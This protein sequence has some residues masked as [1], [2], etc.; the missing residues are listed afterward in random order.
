MQSMLILLALYLAVAAVVPLLA[1]RRPRAAGALAALAPAVTAGWACGH[2]PT[3]ISGGAPAAHAAWARDLGLLLDVRLDALALVMLVLVGGVGAVI[4]VYAGWYVAPARSALT[5]GALVGFAG[6]MSGLVLA[7]NLFVLYV[8][9][10]LTTVCSFLLI[11][12]ERP[13][14]GAHRR[15]AAQAALT[16]TSFGFVMLAGF[17]VLGQAASTYRVSAIVATPP[18]GTPVTVASV[19]ILLGAFAKSAQVPFHP[20]LPAAMV[21]STPVSAY[22]HAAAMVKAGVYL[23]ARLAPA[24]AGL[25]GWRPLVITVG[26][27]TLLVGGWRA[28]RQ[29]DLKRLLAFGTVS[30]LGL[31]MVLL[32]AG[33]R[34]AALAG[35]A[36]LLAHGLFKAPLFLAVGVLERA[37]GTRSAARLAAVRPRLPV[38][39]VAVAAAI[40]SMI[41]VPPFLGY[42]AKEAALSAFIHGT[43]ADMA[44]LAAILAGTTLTIAYGLRFLRAFGG[45]SKPRDDDAVRRAG[46]GGASGTDEPSGRTRRP[47]PAL[48]GP[49]VVLA[50]AGLAA[51]LTPGLLQSLIAPYADTLP[52]RAPGTPGYALALGHG[53]GAPVL[54]SALVLAAGA[55]L[56]LLWPRIEAWRAAL[57]PAPSAQAGYA[58]VLAGVRALSL[59]VIRW[60][61]VGSLPIYLAV[62]V[63]AVLAVP[64]VG[65]AWSLIS[66]A[67]G[68]AAQAARSAAIDHAGLWTGPAGLVL[69]AIVVACAVMAV[70]TA[71]RLSAVVALAAVGYAVCGLF[72]VH[73]A[74]DPALA[75]LVAETLSL[76]MFVLVLRRLPTGFRPGRRPRAVRMGTALLSTGLGCFATAFLLAA[77]S[78]RRENPIA[79]RLARAAADEHLDNVV[80]AILVDVRA[81]DTL[82]EIAVL[83]VAT[84]GVA[85]M[86]LT[87]TAGHE[88]RWGAAWAADEVLEARNGPAGQAHGRNRTRRRWLT[89]PGAPPVGERSLVL[90]VTTRL[91]T[92]TIVLFSL[93]LLF[94]GHDRPGG[95]FVGGLVAGMAFVLRY[96]AGGQPELTAAVRLHPATLVSG[97]LLVAAGT[98]LLAWAPGRAF[99]TAL[100][101]NASPPVLGPIALSSD[102]LFDIGVFLLVLGMVLAVVATLGVI[103]EESPEDRESG[104][105]R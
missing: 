12:G 61:Q 105:S 33:T 51:G 99:L 101:V 86:V 71:G 41:G 56:T 25:A 26:L 70:R 90:D 100:E 82:G 66:G 23:V 77:S 98:G 79:P 14:S 2:A 73:G 76:I 28:L 7:D 29:D 38:L 20:W 48:V 32:G 87:G 45:L 17:V 34:T 55:G 8:C 4:L 22:L 59:Q 95:G 60:T 74:P 54:L 94:S 24:F 21:A 52:D 102:L 43:G 10:E 47:P 18:T 97:G 40:A 96:L 35:A 91:L 50:V 39:T 31:L 103:L 49:V 1:R 92:P 42:I 81:L 88:A 63:I 57:P 58:A 53:L 36:L 104:A 93:Y 85:G 3:V 19:L 69:G 80:N 72:V 15:A 13:A 64:G 9:W 27:A 67:D 84:V 5:L 83:A 68:L 16:T 30:Q 89:A 44:V 65:L 78:L 11:G 75:L 37:T 6:A 46:P 62:V